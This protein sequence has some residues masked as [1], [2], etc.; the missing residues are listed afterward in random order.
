MST[1]E[2]V[3]DYA[4]DVRMLLSIN[5][6]VYPPNTIVSMTMRDRLE[7]SRAKFQIFAEIFK[8]PN[9]GVIRGFDPPVRL[10]AL[11]LCPCD[12][13][14]YKESAICSHCEKAKI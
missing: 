3:D 8:P 12:T 14:N 6:G 11:W 7:E 10:E 1:G 9:D 4:W 5:G 13:Y 2:R